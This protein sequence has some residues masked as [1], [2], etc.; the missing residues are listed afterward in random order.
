MRYPQ[1][2]YDSL[3]RLGVRSDIYGIDGRAASS[4][5]S[6]AIKRTGNLHTEAAPVAQLCFDHL[7]EIANT[8]QYSAKTLRMEEPQLMDE[9]RFARDAQQRLWRFVSCWPK[10]C[11]KAA[12]EDGHGPIR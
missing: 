5:K 11:G 8:K 1:M 10:S 2:P 7:A 9:E 3:K 4:Q 12:G 6:W